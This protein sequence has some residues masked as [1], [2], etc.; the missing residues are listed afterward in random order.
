MSLFV[1]FSIFYTLNK[2]PS[3]GSDAWRAPVLVKAPVVSNSQLGVKG[4]FAS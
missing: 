1:N 3:V 4:R 2:H